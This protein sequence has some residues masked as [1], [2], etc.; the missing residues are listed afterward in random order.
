MVISSS[1]LPKLILSPLRLDS[2]HVPSGRHHAQWVYSVSTAMS[3]PFTR[4]AHTE[5]GRVF[6][7]NASLPV[8]G[9]KL[10]ACDRFTMKKLECTNAG[11]V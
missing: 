7:R 6:F 8:V 4:R 11:I 10:T 1:T 2:S 3:G 5:Q 9:P